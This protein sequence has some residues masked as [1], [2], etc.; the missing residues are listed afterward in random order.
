MN[1]VSNK[2][3]NVKA[4]FNSRY[5]TF[6]FQF[7]IFFSQLLTNATEESESRGGHDIDDNISIKK[8]ILPTCNYWKEQTRFS[9]Q[10]QAEPI[11]AWAALTSIFS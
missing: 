1:S 2:R 11:Y 3:E 5:F 9:L 8:P 4:T 6:A 10:T 7:Y